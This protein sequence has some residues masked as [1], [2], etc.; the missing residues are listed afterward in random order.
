MEKL[1]AERCPYLVRTYE[2][3]KNEDYQYIVME[4]V[5]NGTLIDFIRSQGSKPLKESVAKK[6]MYQ[7]AKAL[8]VLHKKLVIH[9]DIK[10]ANVLYSANK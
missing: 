8:Q 2:T 10:L 1:S 4:H 7:I 5:P 3:F 9:R 6:I